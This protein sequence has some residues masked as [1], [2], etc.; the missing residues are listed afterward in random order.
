MFWFRVGTVN[1]HD[2]V[3]GGMNQS[4]RFVA[5]AAAAAVVA[6]FLRS[7]RNALLHK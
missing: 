1:V 4:L 5:A 3:F 2:T 7:S 6:E